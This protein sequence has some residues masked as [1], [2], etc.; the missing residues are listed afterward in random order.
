MSPRNPTHNELAREQT[1]KA[2]TSAALDLFGNRG[3][4]QTSISAIAQKAGVSKGLIYHYFDSKEAVLQGIFDELVQ[5]GDQI[6]D[7][8]ISRVDPA[9]TFRH[10]IETQF[11]YIT[12]NTP[13]T[14]L[15]IGLVL[16]PDALDKLRLAIDRALENQVE[17]FSSILKDLGCKNYTTECYHLAAT[18][19]GICMGYIVLGDRYPIDAMKRRIYE[20]YLH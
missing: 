13:L 8:A 4:A 16:Q 2:I 11:A 10:M 12:Q 19:D 3:Y 6:M 14:R 20:T 1:R 18:L 15:M 17:K 7:E 9:E 5:I